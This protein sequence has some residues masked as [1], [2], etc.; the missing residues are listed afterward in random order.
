MTG[1]TTLTLG[2]STRLTALEVH[3]TGAD[4]G[5]HIGVTHGTTG[6]MT[7]GITTATIGEDGT[8][9]GTTADIG[10]DGMTLGI[11]ADIGDTDTTTITD[12]T[13]VWDT[14]RIGDITT[15]DRDTDTAAISTETVGMGQGMRPSGWNGYSPTPARQPHEEASAAA[16]VPAEEH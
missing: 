1:G 15:M 16:V 12:G 4:I 11:T 5:A 14:A 6:G 7:L 3:G 9:H 8:T 10:E 13:E 2:I